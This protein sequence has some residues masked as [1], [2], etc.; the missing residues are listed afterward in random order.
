MGTTEPRRLTGSQSR[1]PRWL[2]F[3]LLAAV[4]FR[5]VTESRKPKMDEGAGLVRWQS[6]AAAGA[7]VRETGKLLLYDFTAEWCAPCKLLDEQGWGDAGIA[8]MVGAAFV[9]V[10]VVDRQQEEGRNSPE[11]AALQE[12]YK[13]VSFPTLI[14]AD[15]EGREIA[16]QVGFRNRDTLREFLMDA[17]RRAAVRDRSPR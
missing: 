12:R 9:P 16:R 11:V 15:A 3:L 5:L 17:A 4:V 6:R 13:V 1:L 7:V 8:R 2:L 14:V 10:R